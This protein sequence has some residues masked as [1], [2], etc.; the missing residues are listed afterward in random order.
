MTS[1]KNRNLHMNTHTD[2]KLKSPP[3][4]PPHFTGRVFK[5]LK[6]ASQVTAKGESRYGVVR[7]HREGSFCVQRRQS[8]HMKELLY[9]SFTVSKAQLAL[10]TELLGHLQGGREREREERNTSHC[11]DSATVCGT[12][13]SAVTQR[14]NP[15]N[16][17]KK[18]TG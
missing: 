12:P 15:A 18:P 1:P 11:P 14:E 3:A 4:R 2:Q 7:I 8:P 13:T 5:P 9:S 6:T 17:R 16:T 10:G